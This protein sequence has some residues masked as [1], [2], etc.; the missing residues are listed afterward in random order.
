MAGTSTS[1]SA[2]PV[3]RETHEGSYVLSC[4]FAQFYVPST[5]FQE[6]QNGRVANLSEIAIDE[7]LAQERHYE[8]LILRP[9]LLF[10]NDQTA[11]NSF[12]PEFSGTS[13]VTSYR[14]AV[15]EIEVLDPGL[16]RERLED[17]MHAAM[18]VLQLCFQENMILI[19]I[20]TN[21]IPKDRR[22]ERSAVFG[23]HKQDDYW[24]DCHRSEIDLFGSRSKYIFE[25]DHLIWTITDQVWR[26]VRMLYAMHHFK[27]SLRDYDLAGGNPR[28][29]LQSYERLPPTIEEGTRIENALHNSYKCIEAIYGGELKKKNRNSLITNFLKRGVDLTEKVGYEFGSISREPAIDKVLRLQ[30]IRDSRAGHGWGPGERRSSFY[31]LM[32]F[33]TLARYMLTSVLGAQYN[34]PLVA[35]LRDEDEK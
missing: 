33:Q 32:D 2:L 3:G 29:I 17:S 23:W 28:P 15:Y 30:K 6:F 16:S 22:I 19:P 35:A 11:P 1:N 14:D 9:L 8:S 18:A 31:D 20:P 12:L 13:V 27:E 4:F 21:K 10:S 5:M 34:V 7:F 25:T 26:D 24:L